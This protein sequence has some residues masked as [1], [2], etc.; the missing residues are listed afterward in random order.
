M[1]LRHIE[2]TSGCFVAAM[3]DEPMFVLLARDFTAPFLVEGWAQLRRVMIQIAL[4]P[5]ADNDKVDEAEQLAHAMREWRR[6]APDKPWRETPTAERF[7]EQKVLHF[8][9]ALMSKLRA[10]EAKRG[11]NGAWMRD[12][13]RADLQAHLLAHVAKGDPLDVAAYCLFAWH[14]GWPTAEPA[15]DGVAGD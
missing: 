11:W 4:A 13:W 15:G 5:E 1:A 9:E 2:L 10:A 14:H 6:A 8:A 7:L 3:P 12:D